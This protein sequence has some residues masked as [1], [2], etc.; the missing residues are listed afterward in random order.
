MIAPLCRVE[1]DA[2]PT[3]GPAVVRYRDEEASRQTVERANLAADQR[4]AAAK[5]HRADAERVDRAHDLGFELGQP[6]IRI[7]VVDACETAALWRGR[8]PTCDRRQCTR[9]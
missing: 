8:I 4:H 7:D 1:H 9:R 3:E 2:E 6:R 5:A